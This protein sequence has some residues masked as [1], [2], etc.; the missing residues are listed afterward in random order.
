MS[1][2]KHVKNSA[3]KLTDCAIF[4]LQVH[5]SDIRLHF[6]GMDVSARHILGVLLSLL[7]WMTTDEDLRRLGDMLCTRVSS[8]AQS[9]DSESATENLKCTDR[10]Q[11][12][13]LVDVDVI[14]F[15]R[16]AGE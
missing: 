5:G 9:G 8:E 15:G 7:M 16:G 10:G 13:E 4:R 12:R 2:Y 1:S 11:N 3:K 6:S 14:V